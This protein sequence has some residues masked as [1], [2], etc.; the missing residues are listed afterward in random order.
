M[1]VHHVFACK[2]N[3]GDWLSARGIQSL[4]A[5]EDVVEYF[6]DEPFVPE[7]LERLAAVEPE[8]VV[9]IGG[10]GLFMDYFTPFWEGLLRIESWPRVCIWGVGYCD[11]KHRPSRASDDL[12]GEVVRRSTLCFVRDDLTLGYLNGDGAL[13]PPVPCPSISV[14]VPPPRRPLVLHVMDYAVVGEGGYEATLAAATSFASKTGRHYHEMNNLI[15]DGDE[16]ALAHAL[17]LY[18]ADV[19]VSS[20]LHGCII[21]LAS[22]ARVVAIGAD[23][24]VESFMEAAGLSQWV[25]PLD[26]LDQLGTYL[27]RVDEQRPRRAFLDDA[28]A[29]NR[30]IAKRVCA[31]IER[32]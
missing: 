16:R 15:A 20:R 10:G 32:A 5:P 7:S 13:P 31:L 30:I 18:G 29:E 6:C 1:T 3:V 12:L 24:K 14:V 28:I 8:A 22:G 27:S 2:S 4:L 19:V 21:G 23:R 17:E 9:V 11:I 26:G 25:C